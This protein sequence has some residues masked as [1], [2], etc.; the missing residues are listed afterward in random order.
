[1][2]LWTLATFCTASLLILSGCTAK[3]TPKQEASIDATLP[4]VELTQN[5]TV[6]DMN[7]VAFEWKTIQDPRVKGI[8]VYKL[9]NNSKGDSDDYYDTVDNRFTTHY[10]DSKIKPSTEYRYYFKTFSDKAESRKSAVTLVTSLPLLNSVSWIHSIQNM[11]RMAKII[12][13]PHS[14]E[15]VKSYIIERKTLE[16]DK[17]EKHATVEGRL[18]AEYID[19]ELA[20]NTVYKYRIRVLTYDDLISNPS[21]EVKVVTKPLPQAVSNIQ[22]TRN[23][24]KEIKV[25]WDKTTIKDFYRY[26]V[27]R[28]EKVDKGYELLAKLHN[29][30]FLDKI[31]EDG[32]QYFYRVSVVDA[33]GLESKH[34]DSSIQGVT[35]NRPAAPAISEVKLVNNKVVL[36]WSSADSRT[37]SYVVVKR[38]KKG[39]FDEV[40]QEFKVRGTKFIDPAIEPNTTYHYKVFGIDKNSIKSEPSVEVEIKSPK[41]EVEAVQSGSSAPEVRDAPADT[42]IMETEE[43]IPT[44]DFN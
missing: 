1:M 39:W 22:A 16:E 3:P 13:R 35:L 6:V 26:Y 11:P 28:S 25:T 32:K 12:W 30:Y 36:A 43:I 8:Y 33:D 5:G 15:K 37:V 34:D 20:D 2:K 24:P 10:F 17:W 38:Y 42:P 19:K 7:A 29:N 21:K 31:D 4:V 23:L 18:S 27:Y 9:F 40:T 14:N 41:I 44:Q